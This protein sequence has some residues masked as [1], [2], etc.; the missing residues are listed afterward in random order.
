MRWALIISY[1]ATYF[2]LQ[3]SSRRATFN[4][5]EQNNSSLRL[6]QA[7]N[8]SSRKNSQVK[9]TCAT[10]S[11][12]I[13]EQSRIERE[14]C[15]YK[16]CKISGAEKRGGLQYCVKYKN[17][18]KF[19]RLPTHTLKARKTTTIVF[20]SFSIVVE[21]N[22]FNIN[23]LSTGQEQHKEISHLCANYHLALN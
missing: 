16:Y 22:G 11:T 15:S 14:C 23:Y 21:M 17:I 3:Y 1:F 20:P 4:I 19:S 5:G 2:P 8:D 6:Y 9:K 18:G 12:L 7:G 10:V 13:L